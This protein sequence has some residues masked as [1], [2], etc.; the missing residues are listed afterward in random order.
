MSA[1]IFGWIDHWARWTPLRTAVICDREEVTYAELAARVH[2]VAGQLRRRG[3]G[4]GDRVA[5]CA[6]NRVEVLELLFACGHLGAVLVPVNNRLTAPEARFQLEDCEPSAALAEAAFTDMLRDAGAEPEDLDAFA[7]Q[8]RADRIQAPGSGAQEQ[9]SPESPLLLVYT[10]GTTGTPK[11]AVLSQ[12]SLHY[13]VLNGAAHEGF[14]TGSIVASVLPLFHVGGLNIQT[15]P[16]L[17]AGGTVV[18]AERFDPQGLLAIMRVTVRRR[19]GLPAA[20]IAELRASADRDPAQRSRPCGVE[21]RRTGPCRLPARLRRIR[22]ARERPNVRPAHGRR[23]R[24]AS[25]RVGDRHLECARLLRRARHLGE[26][27]DPAPLLGP[28]RILLPTRLSGRRACTKRST[29]GPAP[30]GPAGE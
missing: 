26:P 19:R 18:L 9:G 1:S 10:S 13:T 22:P 20:G 12:R 23:R 16:C 7:S 3:V 29:P 25:R 2:G 11:G 5:V 21:L 8:A 15:V 6:L 17:F 4:A 30:A 14:G 24:G 28:L 27:R